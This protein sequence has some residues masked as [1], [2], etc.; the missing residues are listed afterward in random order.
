MLEATYLGNH[1]RHFPYSYTINQNTLDP[2]YFSL[3]TSYLNTSVA[4]PYAGMVPGSPG[5]ATITRATLL[6]PFPYYSGV[7]QSYARTQSYNGNYLYVTATRRATNGLQIIGSCT[8]G[9]LMDVPI[10]DLLLNL[11]G[12]AT[13]SVNGPQ[14][15]RDPSGDYSVDVQ[16]VTH[17]VTISGLYDLPFGPGKKFLSGSSAI[18]RLLGGFQFSVIMK[19]NLD[20]PCDLRNQQ[21]RHCH[22]T[23]HPTRRKRETGE[24]FSCQVVQYRS[25]CESGRLHIWQCTPC[26]CSCARSVANEL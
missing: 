20:A 4:N 21:P 13:N 24:S 14:N 5:A 9:K 18:D 6:K 11:P 1:G 23:K 8:Y 2:K 25:V 26:I 3:G 12:A 15:W 17:R 7:Y 16:D 22:A 19:Q 10:F